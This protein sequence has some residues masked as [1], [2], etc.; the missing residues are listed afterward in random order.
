M[1]SND[2]GNQLNLIVASARGALF[3]QS[4]L[5]HLTYGAFDIAFRKVQA[6]AQEVIEFTYP[7]GWKADSQPVNVTKKYSKHE[8]LAQYQFL[9]LKQLASNAIVHLVTLME[10]MSND[11]LRTV[12]AKYPQKLG[13][14]KK[15]SLGIVLG[16]NSIEVI[17]AHAIDA[18]LNELSYKSPTDYAEFI[19]KLIGIKLLECT[20]FHRYVEL[21]ATRDVYIHN[22]GFANDIY[23]RKAGHHARVAVG[24]LLPTDLRYFLESFEQ[25]VQLTEWWE[26]QLHEKW[27]SSEFE[28][29]KGAPVAPPEVAP[30]Q[31]V[32]RVSEQLRELAAKIA[33]PTKK[34][35]DTS[36]DR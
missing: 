1:S 25:C 23:V 31:V 15:I 12:I 29:R 4:E 34:G 18:L 19:E 32:D 5:A 17:H 36:S 3:R 24:N 30:L 2:L 35:Y 9:G 10:A 7:V 6:D 16:S 33:R 28:A 11:L 26:Q 13:G 14:E 27:Y 20:A 21:K 22:R 8:L